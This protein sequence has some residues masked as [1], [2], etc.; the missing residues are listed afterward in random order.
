MA[1]VREKGKLTDFKSDRTPH[2]AIVHAYRRRQRGFRKASLVTPATPPC[3]STFIHF[4]VFQSDEISPTAAIFS[5]CK[6]VLIASP[7]PTTT[8][9]TCLYYTGPFLWDPLDSR[10]CQQ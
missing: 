10:V 2:S 8:T 9:L 3:L 5:A 6:H 7:Y 4:V 1:Y